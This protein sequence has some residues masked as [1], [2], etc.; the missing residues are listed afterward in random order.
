MQDLRDEE[1][2]CQYQKGDMLAMDE[3]LRRY[4]N[5]VY[6]FI[7]RLSHNAEEAEDIAQEV[8]LRVHQYRA[9]YTSSGKF[10]TW[11]FSITHNLFIDSV[12][13]RKWLVFWPRREDDPDNPVEFSSPTLSAAEETE[14]N[15]LAETVKCCIQGLPFLQ[16]EALILR[17][18]EQMK[19]EEIAMILNKSLG[20]VKT[21]IHRARENLKNKLLPYAEEI[22]GGYHA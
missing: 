19:Y 8:F 9:R 16:K 17:E 13:K 20:T 11:I 15:D 21:L 5:P 7:Y 1:L 10:S 6:R 4:K 3:I 12:R 2:M 18:Y 22:K 14:R